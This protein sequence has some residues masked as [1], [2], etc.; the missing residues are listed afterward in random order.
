MITT[1][2][3][4]QQYLSSIQYGSIKIVLKSNLQVIIYV[5]YLTVVDF[6]CFLVG[7]LSLSYRLLQLSDGYKVH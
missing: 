1:V 2:S 4:L 6:L 5:F 3:F 7:Y